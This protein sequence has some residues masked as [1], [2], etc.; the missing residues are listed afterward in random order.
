MLA[1]EFGK[2][3]DIF[4]NFKHHFDGVFPSDLIP[5]TLR[6]NHFIICNTDSSNGP[7]IHWYCFVNIEN[8]IECF[9]SLGIDKDKKIFLS[10]LQFLRKQYIIDVEFNT[11]PVQATNSTSCGQFVIY[12]LV[13]RMHNK[14]MDFDD[15]LNEIF[16][17]D[18]TQNETKVCNFIAMHW[19]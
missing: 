15:L 7:G 10:S 17:I 19:N 13:N 18:P 2:Y 3:F 11:T 4:P 9:D 1:S 14:D 16:V 8:S 6:K 12:F 5:K